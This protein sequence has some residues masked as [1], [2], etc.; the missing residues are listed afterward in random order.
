MGNKFLSTL[1]AR[2]ATKSGYTTKIE[3]SISIHAPREGSDNFYGSNAR[4]Y[5]I[6]IHAPREGSDI[7]VSGSMSEE[8]VFLSTLPARGATNVMVE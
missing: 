4:F 1:P 2:G 3:A 8:D 7:T 5:Y 6:S